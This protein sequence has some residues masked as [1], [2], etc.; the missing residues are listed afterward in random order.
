MAVI[1]SFIPLKHWNVIRTG[2]AQATTGQTDWCTV[3]PWAR[4]MSI[5]F[6]LSAVGGVT[7]LA[8]FSIVVPDLTTK[9]DTTGVVNLAAYTAFTQITG[10]ARLIGQIGPGITGIADD[11]ATSATG[12]SNFAINTPLPPI[13][14][15]KLVFDRTDGNETYTYALGTALMAVR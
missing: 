11:V 1:S 6:N 8:D 12:N 5:D 7:P 14:G 15:F 4:Y 13:I 10:V 3:P 2:A 9:D